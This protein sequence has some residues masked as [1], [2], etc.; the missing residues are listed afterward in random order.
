[1][2]LQNIKDISVIDGDWNKVSDSCVENLYESVDVSKD[3]Q[4]FFPNVKDL[5]KKLRLIIYQ[6]FDTLVVSQQ[7]II[8]WIKS[9]IY[10]DSI[11]VNFSA[12]KPGAKCVWKSSNLRG[13][14]IFNISKIFIS[15]LEK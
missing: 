11:I 2:S 9:S 10:K 4:V 14:F 1:M 8:T 7:A 3:L 15:N 6:H 5:Q 12:L 13:V